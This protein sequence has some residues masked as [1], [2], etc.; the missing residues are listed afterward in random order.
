MHLLLRLHNIQR[1]NTII[2]EL[3]RF[4]EKGFCL[5]IRAAYIRTQ[6]L[7]CIAGSILLNKLIKY[8]LSGERAAF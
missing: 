2:D 3:N 5:V 6:C 1:L 4:F 7:R 8:E